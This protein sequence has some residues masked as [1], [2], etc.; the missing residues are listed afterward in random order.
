MIQQFGRAGRTLTMDALALLMVEPCYTDQ[1]AREL[2]E[3]AEKKEAK[4]LAK[5]EKAVKAAGELSGSL[6]VASSAAGGARPET[7]ARKRI[8]LEDRTNTGKAVQATSREGTPAL[9]TE[10]DL[11][12][13]EV[14][15]VEGVGE[16][17]AVKAGQKRKRRTTKKTDLPQET[18]DFVNAG[19][20]GRP[21][22]R[23]KVAIDY[24][25]VP[26]EGESCTSTLPRIST[27]RA[28][29]PS[30]TMLGGLPAMH[31]QHR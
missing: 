8:A 23:R 4:D 29:F 20:P 26:P 11:S 10:G 15:V 31:Q 25:G 12:E 6:G 16:T 19:E 18:M 27:H 24:F 9:D 14:D 17:L 28:T 30:G 22:C 5:K 1:K 2:A 21:A 3:N 13:D 7:P